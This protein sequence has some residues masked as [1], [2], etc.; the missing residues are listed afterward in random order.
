MGTKNLGAG[1][2]V[3]LA[4]TNRRVNPRSQTDSL[5]PSPQL[6]TAVTWW[7]SQGVM[8]LFLGA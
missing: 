5:Q 2:L 4:S 7:K 1:S 6:A 8:P 3:F